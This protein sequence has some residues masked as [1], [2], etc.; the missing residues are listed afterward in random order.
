M[1]LLEAR[2]GSGLLREDARGV[3]VSSVLLRGGGGGIT[4]ACAPVA[5][6]N[7]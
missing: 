7:E 6:Q 2:R 5:R 3:G 4:S 1:L